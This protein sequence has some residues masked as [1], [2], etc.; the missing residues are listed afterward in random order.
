MTPRC[1]YC[2]LQVGGQCMRL[3]DNGEGSRQ[4]IVILDKQCG[5]PSGHVWRFFCQGSGF[6]PISTPNTVP[7]G[8]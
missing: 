4:K 2:R 6:E 5:D 8:R 7:A 1:S 3:W